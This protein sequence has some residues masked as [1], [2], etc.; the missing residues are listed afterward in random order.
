MLNKALKEKGNGNRLR[1]D[2]DRS[3]ISWLH[4]KLPFSI[5]S[6]KPKKKR[7]LYLLYF[8]P[9][10]S[11]VSLTSAILV[12]TKSEELFMRLQKKIIFGTPK[13]EHA[14]Y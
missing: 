8:L 4:V 3:A 14:D 10:F 6:K 11:F 13:I 9:H 5:K 2:T 7:L 1:D 12:L